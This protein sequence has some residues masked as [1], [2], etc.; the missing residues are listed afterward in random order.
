MKSKFKKIIIII[1]III[2]ISIL[3]RIHYF[4]YLFKLYIGINKTIVTSIH[5]SFH[6]SMYIWKE[7]ME[8]VLGMS[9]K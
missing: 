6:S 4:S 5:F 1:A 2:I 9:S 3:F 7:G 8:A